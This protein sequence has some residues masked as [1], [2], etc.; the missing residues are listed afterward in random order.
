VV[1]RWQPDDRWPVQVMALRDELMS[2]AFDLPGQWWP[3][4]PSVVGGRDRTAGGTWCASDPATGVTAVVLNRPQPRNAA[5]GAPSRGVL[6]LLAV[7]HEE[8][9]PQ[10]LD[11]KGMAGFNLVLVTPS[12]SNWWCFDGNE[13]RES[14]LAPGVSMFTP[15]GPLEQVDAR[16]RSGGARLTDPHASTPDVWRD[17]LSVLEAAR[18]SPDPNSLLV[19]KPVGDDSYET[20]FAQFI[21][22]APGQ[23][24]LDYQSHP[25]SRLTTDWTTR[26]WGG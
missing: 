14:T 6:P 7:Q 19:R 16:L 11:V 26:S 22:A 17:W 4:Q 24:R 8:R 10:Y 25:A 15:R 9:W 1:S 5:V 3:E 18:P 20:V 2:R 12:A 13:L 21:A 23:L